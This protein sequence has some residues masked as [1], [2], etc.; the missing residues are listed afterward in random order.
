MS[1]IQL[2][3][4]IQAVQARY[5]FQEIS[6]YRDNPLLEA[7]PPILS[8]SEVIQT[9]AQYPYFD[10]N[11]RQMDSHYRFHLI[12]RLFS[13]FFQPLPVHLDLE[14][15]ISRLI[16]QG[17]INRNPLAAHH[18]ESLIKGYEGI[19]SGRIALSQNTTAA[20]LTII[21]ASGMG[22]ST[23]VNRI[24]HLYPQVVAHSIYKGQH[25]NQLQTV[26]LKLECP[27]DSS[28]RGLVNNFFTQMDAILGTDYFMKFGKNSRLS[29][30]SLLPVVSQICRNSCLGLLVIDEIQNLNARSS[31]GEQMLNFF[32]SLSNTLGGIPL[33]FI[34]TPKAVSVLQSEFRQARRGSGQ[35]DLIWLPMKREDQSWHLFLQ[36]M[37]EYQWL[38]K[39]VPLTNE[40]SNCIYE[41]SCGISDIAVKLFVMS[42]IRAITSGKEELT[43]ELITQVAKESLKLVQPMLNAM[44]SGNPAKIAKYGDINTINI[45]GFVTAEQN[46]VEVSALIDD[47][48]KQRQEQKA[49][50][51]KLKTD[52]IFRLSILGVDEKEARSSVEK[53]ITSNSGALGLKEL[54]QK[55]YKLNVTGDE[56]GKEAGE[57]M[58]NDLRRIVRQGKEQG[59]SAIQALTDAGFV[60]TEFDLGAV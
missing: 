29:A 16:R 35:G 52:A 26:W 21:G 22:K 53:V 44:R 45:E 58:K 17:Y 59:I 55:A 3:N 28:V 15:R 51:E 19:V 38:R 60:Q 56:G 27:H 23:T 49:N 4:G 18:N 40:L 41:Q 8:K 7:L 25:F 1:K 37:W 57:K 14:S 30:Q 24:L 54:V 43:T 12:Q 32:V 36:G 31:G 46:K 20:G 34:G 2:P 39:P 10:P 6:D 9:M 13:L 42:Q 48:Q 11:E 5:T 50:I 33:I 47:F